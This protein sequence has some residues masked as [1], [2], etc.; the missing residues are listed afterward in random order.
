MF[1]YVRPLKAEMKI[2]DYESYK[3][4]Y[5]GLCRRM[6]KDYGILARLAL[7]YDGTMLA[8]LS[9]SVRK[10]SPCV[11][12][13]RC[14][15][16][17][18]KK[19]RFC[20]SEGESMALAGAV[21]VIMTYYKLQDTITDAGFVKRNLARL[22]KLLFGGCFRRAKKACPV[23]AETVSVMMAAQVQAE[24]A[25]SAID[26]AAD[27]TAKALSVICQMLSDDTQTKHILG[28]FGY[29]LGRWIYLMD[30]ADDMEKDRRSGNFNPFLR[31]HFDKT[32]CNEVLNLTVSQI[33]LA[34]DLLEPGEYRNI[35]DNIIYEG[36][37][38]RQSDCLSDKSKT[39]PA[40]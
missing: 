15:C 28:T 19:C 8:M 7:S 40:V 26:R 32:S 11:T 39:P 27:P 35:L 34:Y 22:G 14:V 38:A 12:K 5:C 13:G 3:S 31:Q 16:N 17:P 6:G 29:Y 25:E 18:L 21:S 1:G 4:V 37:K 20:D 2:K 30:A 10:E 9:M 36:L 23:I 24:N 33:V